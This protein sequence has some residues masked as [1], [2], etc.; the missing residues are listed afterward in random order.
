MGGLLNHS[1]SCPASALDVTQR[2][3]QLSPEAPGLHGSSAV[4]DGLSTHSGLQT[5]SGSLQ[6]TQQTEELPASGV[7]EVHASGLTAATAD[8][9]STFAQTPE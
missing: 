9:P 6:S 5:C 4:G 2:E 1:F 8:G 3:V 7:P